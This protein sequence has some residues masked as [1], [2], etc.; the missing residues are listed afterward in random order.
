MC[1]IFAAVMTF[2]T[3]G[4]FVSS[5]SANPHPEIEV[6]TTG[7]SASTAAHRWAKLLSEVGF[8]NVR[9]RG[10][11]DGDQPQI[12]Q[13]GTAKN[14]SYQVVGVLGADDKLSLKGGK[15]GIGDRAKLTQFLEKLGEATDPAAGEKRRA[16]GLR[17]SS[18]RSCSPDCKL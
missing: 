5:A 17:T 1:R 2:L 18:S 10:G 11:R 16:F 13:T 6:L 15:F 7:L 3:F 8:D 12:T 9:I 14:P 4:I